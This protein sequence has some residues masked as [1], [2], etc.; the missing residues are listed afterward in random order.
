MNT[1]NKAKEV[2]FMSTTN[3]AQAPI[4]DNAG[5]MKYNA[6]FHPNHKKPWLADDERMLIKFYDQVGKV[7]ISLALGRTESTVSE[8]VRALR[9]QGKMPKFFK[10]MKKNIKRSI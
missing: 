3:K 8:R 9:E 5:R 2:V 4:Y 10:G 6:V 7:E 1:V